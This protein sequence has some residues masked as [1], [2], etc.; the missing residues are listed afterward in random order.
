M[1]LTTH[2]ILWL[3]LILCLTTIYR[4]WVI[5]ENWVAAVTITKEGQ[6]EPLSA[7]QS[8]VLDYSNQRPAAW[9]GNF[10]SLWKLWLILCNGCGAVEERNGWLG[11]GN[12]FAFCRAMKTVSLHPSPQLSPCSVPSAVRLFLADSNQLEG[13][14]CLICM[15]LFKTKKKVCI[16]QG[17]GKQ[18][19]E[20]P[21]II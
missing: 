6:Q 13:S 15:R 3:A 16:S 19:K 17:D 8:W 4:G 9:K 7:K 18:R 10:K 21:F 20:M 5:P 12:R 11:E 1:V 14:V 2:F